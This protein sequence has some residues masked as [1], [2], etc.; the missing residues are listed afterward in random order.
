MVRT[1]RAILGTPCQ[2]NSAIYSLYAAEA[3]RYVTFSNKLLASLPIIVDIVVG[4]YL[5]IELEEMN[6]V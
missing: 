5:L 2:E 3:D 6:P 1:L 4:D